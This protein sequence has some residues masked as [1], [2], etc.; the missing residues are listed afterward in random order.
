MKKLTAFLLSLIMAILPF[1]VSSAE[2][3]NAGI[4]IAVG[5]EKITAQQL[6]EA[7]ELSMFRGAIECAGYGYAYDITDPLNI[8]DEEDKVVYDLELNI[9]IQTKAK[10]KG[11]DTLTPESETILRDRVDETW[12]R[13]MEIAM[14][15][16]G[17]YFLPAGDFEQAEDP[18]ENIR[19]YFASFG[20][21]KET[22]AESMTRELVDEQLKA[23]VTA[24]MEGGEDDIFM[25]YI[26]WILER[27]DES[28]ITE[29][30]EVITAVMEELG[31]R[32]AD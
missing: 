19:R 17:L 12:N 10:E 15:E 14:S 7:I 1:A 16:N 24:G 2:E 4:A 31:W 9:V 20:L 21:T 22:L 26:D 11:V 27:Y 3:E 8:E 29:N 5:D 18:E 32:A 30:R 6:K 23:A 25:H 28:D 13:Y